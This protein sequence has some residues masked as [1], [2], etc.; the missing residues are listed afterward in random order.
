MHQACLQ[1]W[2]KSSDARCCELC[3]YE[4]VMETRLKPLRKVR[5]GPPG[6]AQART[7]TPCCGAGWA[8]ADLGPLLWEVGARVYIHVTGTDFQVPPCR[9]RLFPTVRSSCFLFP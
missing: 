1:Q 4:F 9:S 6:A 8:A 7:A 2:I 5:A 3:K